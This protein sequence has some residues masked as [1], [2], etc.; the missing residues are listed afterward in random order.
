M[1]NPQTV[2]KPDFTGKLSRS[3]WFDLPVKNLSDAMS[4]YEGLLGWSYRQMDQSSESN[5]VMIEVGG[6]LIGGLRQVP[7][8]SVSSTDQPQSPLIYFT[9]DRLAEKVARAKELG[10]KL[11]GSIV[12]V[13]SDRGRYQWIRDREGNLIGLWSKHK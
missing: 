9:V 11:V 12:D 10:A 1:T 13:G 7:N 3:V 5:Y 4:F 2:L 8:V 6:E